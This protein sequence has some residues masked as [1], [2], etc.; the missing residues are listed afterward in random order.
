MNDETAGPLPDPD[1]TG[2]TQIRVPVRQPASA[3]RATVDWVHSLRVLE[4]NEIG[5][6]HRVVEPPLQ[7]GRRAGN[8]LVIPDSE[9]SSNH[10]EVRAV[11]GQRWL[12]VID[13]GSTN[14]TYAGGR[15]V[16]GSAR[17]DDGELLQVGRHVLVH[18][19]RSRAEMEQAEAADRELDRARHY[20]ESL[21]PAPMR[22][23]P[24]RT[25][26]FFRPSAMLGGDAFGYL[27]LGADLFA[28]YLIDVTGHGVGVAMHT[29]SVM[30]VLRQRA[31]PETDFADPAQVLA[32]LNAMFQMEEHDGLC[33]TMWY[34]VYDQRSRSLAFASA[35]HHPALLRAPGGGPV[36]RLATRSL[37]LGALADTRYAATRVP[38]APGSQL[39]LFSDGLFEVTDLDG[40]TWTLDDVLP[41]IDA[42]PSGDDAPARLYRTVRAATGNRPLDDD[43]SIVHVT[44]L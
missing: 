20:V 29:V 44:F 9:V 27:R 24:V 32:R 4:G 30:N 39:H 10:C 16:H 6:R 33:F 5:R 2:T 28:G 1:D 19:C 13:R 31:L 17:L 15:R 22:E 12:E 26:W 18:E 41:L 42:L 25:E 11:A 35:G 8:G 36:Q 37:P 43:C 34:G 38:V 14:G 40:R 3:D 21:L 7:I 23:G